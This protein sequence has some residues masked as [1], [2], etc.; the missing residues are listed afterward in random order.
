MSTAAVKVCLVCGKDVA[1][2]KRVKD[3]QGNYYCEACQAAA[4]AKR[5]GAPKPV[6]V[7][8]GDAK[9]QPATVAAKG[10]DGA[11]EGG[12][13][14]RGPAK[15]PEFCPNCGA[16]V[17]A[18]RKLCIKCNRDVTKMEKVIALKKEEAAPP[19]KEEVFATWVGRVARVVM[20]TVIVGVVVFIL[21]GIKL[22]FMP[23]GL[24]DEFPKTREAAVREFLGYIAEGGEKNYGKAFMLISFRERSTG[25]PDEEKKFDMVFAQMHDDFAKKYG[26][27][28]LSKMKLENAGS[29]D[30][31]TDDEVDYKLTLG[32]DTYTI[33]TQAQMDITT[34][35]AHMTLPR[36]KKPVFNEDGKNRFGILDIAE[37][38]VHAKR[39]M[40][41]IAGSGQ[42]ETLDVP[43]GM[44]MNQ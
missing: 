28:W 35:T 17:F 3:A 40:V 13:E 39:H 42:P 27:D 8:M 33:A 29:N 20:W 25:L 11:G 10:G 44:Q 9:K 34:A 43:P 12:G 7:V 32:G 5:Q 26:A 4:A 21:W 31:Y 22:Q 16:K 18:N 37:Y 36:A 15:L 38:K 23:P 2:A 41:D 30:M 24:W 1:N 6:A 19:S 14:S